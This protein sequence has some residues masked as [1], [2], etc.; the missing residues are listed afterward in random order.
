MKRRE[1]W[2][3]AI[4]EQFADDLPFGGEVLGAAHG[5]AEFF[6]ETGADELTEAA[7]GDGDVADFD[8]EFCGEFGV[9]ADGAGAVEH[10]AESGEEGGLAATGAAGFGGGEGFLEEAEGPCAVEFEVGAALASVG[11]I[12]VG[13]GVAVERDDQ[14]AAAAFLG[15]AIAQFV[16]DEPLK[17]AVEET[18]E[19]SASAE[20]AIGEIAAE[21]DS[22]EEF[23]AEVI[24]FVGGEAAAEIGEDDRAVA[25][26]EPCAAYGRASGLLE[27]RPLGAGIY[28]KIFH[29][30]GMVK[31]RISPQPLLSTRNLLEHR[32]SFSGVGRRLTF[33]RA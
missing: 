29:G 14:L 15:G 8:A 32:R 33:R 9:G 31:A 12:R 7:E 16:A 19:T 10:G 2:L 3:S 4:F 22:G 21:D 1:I 26:A 30:R 28:R 23:L 20:G 5:A 27:A 11:E 17:G 6:V 25:F 24:G 13:R 18:A